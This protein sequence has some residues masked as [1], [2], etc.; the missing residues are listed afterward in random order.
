MASIIASGVLQLQ[1]TSWLPRDLTHD[2]VF[3]VQKDGVVL[4]RKV[5]VQR[6]LTE[7]GSQPVTQPGAT[8]A[9]LA[10]GMLLIEVI[11]G[12]VLVEE[13]Q[14]HNRGMP[15]HP[16]VTWPGTRQQPGY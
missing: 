4:F 2:E 7:S 5:F 15:D 13:L 1:G 16:G 12:R 8:A 14:L 3:L 10:V 6:R 11:L 9:T